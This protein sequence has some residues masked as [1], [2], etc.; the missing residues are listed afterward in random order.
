MSCFFREPISTFSSLEK[1]G[2]GYILALESEDEDD[3]DYEDDRDDWTPYWEF[4][5]DPD[6]EEGGYWG[7]DADDEDWSDIYG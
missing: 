6:L 3:L 2:T 4:D 5:F 7:D 1:R